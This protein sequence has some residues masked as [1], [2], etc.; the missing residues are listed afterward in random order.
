MLLNNLKHLFVDKGRHD[1]D[2]D[3]ELYRHEHGVQLSVGMI[4]REEADPALV[5]DWV[6]ASSFEF[7]FLDVLEEDGLFGVCD[8]VVVGLAT[9][10]RGSTLVGM[11][12]P[13]IMTPLGRPVVPLE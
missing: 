6:F 5:G 11:G 4:E 2:W 10:I 9:L 12:T 3:V 1:V 8:Q 7:G 13:T